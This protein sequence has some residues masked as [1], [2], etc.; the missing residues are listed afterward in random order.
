MHIQVKTSIELVGAVDVFSLDGN[1]ILCM[2][3]D[4]VRL[5]SVVRI[6]S[7]SNSLINFMTINTN[8]FC[9]DW[10]SVILHSWAYFMKN[11]LRR[12]NNLEYDLTL[13]RIHW[14]LS[15]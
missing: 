2:E 7:S 5:S 6:K 8:C 11:A 9:G 10:N 1:M 14:T 13:M 12:Y 4:L 3:K 15:H